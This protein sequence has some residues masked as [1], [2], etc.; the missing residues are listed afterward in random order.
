MINR[1]LEIPQES[2]GYSAWVGCDYFYEKSRYGGSSNSYKVE[3]NIKRGNKGDDMMQVAMEKEMDN[4]RCE[5]KK[6]LGLCSWPILSEKEMIGGVGPCFSHSW[7]EQGTKNLNLSLDGPLN[8][9]YEGGGLVHEDVDI[10]QGSYQ[11]CPFPPGFGPCSSTN[12]VHHLITRKIV[13][14]SP[15]ISHIEGEEEEGAP[16]KNRESDNESLER[17]QLQHVFEAKL[18]CEDAGMRFDEE[19]ETRVVKHL[20]K[21]EG[22]PMSGGY[23]LRS[24]NNSSKRNKEK[25]GYRLPLVHCS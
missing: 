7:T 4:R 5:V 24:K 20:K 11:S 14:M 2:V 16:D 1:E 13:N 9:S 6:H 3:L 10:P 8:Q 18:L 12:H 25:K 15:Q 17:H 22:R 21:I 23:N 19:D